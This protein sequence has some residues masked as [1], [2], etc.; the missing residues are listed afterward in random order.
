MPIITLSVNGLNISKKIQT[1]SY[2][3]KKGEK[4]LRSNSLQEKY[5]YKSQNN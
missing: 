1:F 4:R 3:L 5:M 2:L